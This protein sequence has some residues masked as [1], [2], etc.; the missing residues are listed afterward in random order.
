ME[1]V[2]RPIFSGWFANERFQGMYVLLGKKIEAVNSYLWSL[3]GKLREESEWVWR[4]PRETIGVIL[5]CHCL[6]VVNTKVE[7]LH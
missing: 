2:E 1:T 4:A 3:N 6:F 7:F 5:A